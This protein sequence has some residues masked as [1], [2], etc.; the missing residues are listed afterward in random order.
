MDQGALGK[1]AGVLI[2]AFAVLGLGIGVMH[3]FTGTYNPGFASYPLIVKTHVALGAFYLFVGAFQFVP[4][5]RRKWIGYHRAA[6]R[7]LAVAALFVGA[8]AIF[9]GL[10]IPFSGVAEQIV[11]TVFGAFFLVSIVSAYRNVKQG[12]IAAHRE[13]MIRAYAIGAGI[14]TMRLIFVPLLILFE[15]SSDEVAAQLSIISFTTAFVVHALV[16]EWWIR[17]T[18]PRAV[19]AAA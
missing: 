15:V 10:V 13:W 6:G 8:S 4:A 17:R 11:M 7:V 5:I 18:R 9:M 3:F 1:I 16:A 2:A 14:V 12:N 19:A